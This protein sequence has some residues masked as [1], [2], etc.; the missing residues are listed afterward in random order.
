MKAEDTIIDKE[1]MLTCSLVSKYP[2][3]SVE[4][5]IKET[6]IHQAEISFK[7]G[8]KAMYDLLVDDTYTHIE[9]KEGRY[10]EYMVKLRTLL[11]IRSG[12]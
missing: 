10:S 5:V 12:N 3:R 2:F 8:A 7:A 9:M 1:E 11:G 6:C 4:D